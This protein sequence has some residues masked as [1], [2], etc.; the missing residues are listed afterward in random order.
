MF[1]HYTLEFSAAFLR[2]AIYQSYFYKL[3]SVSVGFSSSQ[4]HFLPR[5]VNTVTIY[6]LKDTAVPVGNETCNNSV[7]PAKAISLNIK[8]HTQ[9]KFLHYHLCTF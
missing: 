6:T 5:I 3:K 9:P 1:Y 8:I 7:W 2:E 4:S